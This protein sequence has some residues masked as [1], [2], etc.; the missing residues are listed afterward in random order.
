M[1]L[2]SHFKV[3]AVL[4]HQ[5][6]IILVIP[7]EKD[8][9]FAGLGIVIFQQS[10]GANIP[11][12]NVYIHIGIDVFQVQSV[13]DGRLAADSG[14]I[15]IFLVAG[16]DTLD[17]NRGFRIPELVIFHFCGQLELGHNPVILSVSILIGFRLVLIGASGQNHHPVLDFALNHVGPNQDFGREIPFE[18]GKSDD[19]GVGQGFNFGVV[20]YFSD[21]IIQIGLDF[22]T[23]D[24]CGQ[25]GGQSA[26]FGLFFHQNHVVA[27]FS[28]SDG[29]VHAGHP[30]ADHQAPLNNGNFLLFKGMQGSG[31]GHRHPEQVLGLCR[32]IFIGIGMDPGILVANVGHFKQVLVQAAGLHC[33]LEYRL[34]G[35]RAAGCHHYAI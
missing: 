24:G 14:A 15:G 10:V 32:C 26:Q 27:L 4:L 35:F 19:Q 13:F 23:F 28:Q 29:S 33:V 6:W 12:Q 22:G 3:I 7:E 11:V 31:P 30:A 25:T 5:R 21:Q 16:T 18:P 17:H 34:V 1:I 20:G 8:A 9:F 2:E